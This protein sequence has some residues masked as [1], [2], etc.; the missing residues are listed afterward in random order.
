MDSI[1]DDSDA[2][3]AWLRERSGCLTSSCMASA[4]AYTKKGEP[5]ADR[6]KLMKNLCAE[7]M[8]DQSAWH[9]VNPAMQWG[10]DHEDEARAM[11]EAEAGV[12]INHVRWRFT[13]HPTIEFCGASDD[14]FIGADGM[15]EIKCPTTATMVDWRLAGLVPEEYKP[16]MTL[17]LC[18]TRRRWCDF[19]AYDPRIKNP[20]HRLFIR[21]FEPTAEERAN[22]EAAAVQFLAELDR[23]FEAVVHCPIAA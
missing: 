11:Y 13:R 3:A 21:R 2:K 18:C 7:R 16:Q 6:S 12:I 8:T 17:E 14:G 23:M 4:M 10:L 1:F 22:V 15:I 19:I 5:T 20:A 9:Y